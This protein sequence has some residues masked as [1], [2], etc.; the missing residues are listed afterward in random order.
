MIGISGLSATCPS[1][2]IPSACVWECVC[3]FKAFVGYQGHTHGCSSDVRTPALP[4]PLALGAVSRPQERKAV[5]EPVARPPPHACIFT[6][7]RLRAWACPS[8]SISPGARGDG[9]HAPRPAP[10]CVRAARSPRPEPLLPRPVQRWEP[11]ARSRVWDALDVHQFA[12]SKGRCCFRVVTI[13]FAIVT[14]SDRCQDPVWVSDA[15]D[16][17]RTQE[18]RGVGERVMGT[19]DRGTK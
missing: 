10:G 4:P 15:Q 14:V 12:G 17:R 3:F 19:R 9:L 6:G 7:S 5:C 11:R 13:V 2:F 1:P 16:G 8:G 18:A